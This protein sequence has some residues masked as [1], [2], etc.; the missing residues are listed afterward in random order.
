MTAD[1][2]SP[3]AGGAAARRLRLPKGLDERAIDDHDFAA[4]ERIGRAIDMAVG[5]WLAGINHNRLVVTLATADFAP[6]LSVLVRSL[7]EVSDVPILVLTADDF[8]PA[9]NAPDVAFL[10]VPLLVRAGHV[11][12]AGADHLAITL[13]KLWLFWLTRP[14]RIAYIDAD[15]LVLRPVDDL[16]AG[17]GF[18]AAPDLFLNYTTRGFNAG[19]FAYTPSSAISYVLF[20]RLPM[21]AVGDGDQGVL[22]A[23]FPDW[24]PLPQGLNFM[25]AHALVRAQ[26]QDKALRIVHYT[27]SKPWRPVSA[28]LGDPV[29]APLDE[30]W[31]ARLTNDELSAIAPDWRTRLSEA[32]A[33]IASWTVGDAKRAVGQRGRRWLIALVALLAVQ[34]LQAGVL[35][36]LLLR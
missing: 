35:A 31:T 22:N 25:R 5:G 12:P 21:L 36:W 4:C 20:R 24:R 27:R 29:L 16:F 15:C 9:P 11:F 32:E 18:A 2:A 26:A 23:C 1:T 7:R 14:A 10:K 34:L 3:P 6:G 13:N 17:E 30:L 33:S 28:S 8:A 19:V